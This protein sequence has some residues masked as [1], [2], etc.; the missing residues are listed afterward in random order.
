MG[1]ALYRIHVPS[2][3]PRLLR[4]LEVH[5][6]ESALAAGVVDHVG[7]VARFRSVGA[8]CVR[9]PVLTGCFAAQATGRGSA[10]VRKCAAHRTLRSTP[11]F[12]Q[13][14]GEAEREGER[15]RGLQLCG[16]RTP[17]CETRQSKLAST[18]TRQVPHVQSVFFVPSEDQ[19]TST[20]V[21]VTLFGLIC[22]R[23]V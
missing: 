3:V 17:M 6:R 18:I 9:A 2:K 8:A 15:E 4:Q 11:Y 7:G 13:R 14:S 10:A 5:A 22:K 21:Q 1:T 12:V 19:M 23:K 20:R 16:H